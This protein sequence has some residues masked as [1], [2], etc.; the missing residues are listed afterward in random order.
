MPHETSNESGSGISVQH[1]IGLAIFKHATQF[2]AFYEQ[3]KPSR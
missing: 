2:G 1:P 3:G